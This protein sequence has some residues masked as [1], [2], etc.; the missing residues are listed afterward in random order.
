MR[1]ATVRIAT[2][3][4]KTVAILFRFGSSGRA[5]ITTTLN[6]YSRVLPDMQDSVADTMEAVLS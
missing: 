5:S 2:R 3:K 6:T 4:T 1:A